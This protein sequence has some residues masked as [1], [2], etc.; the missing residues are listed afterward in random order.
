MNLKQQADNGTLPSLKY[1]KS[2][3]GKYVSLDRLKSKISEL[4]SKQKKLRTRY[5]FAKNAEKEL[6]SIKRNVD[7]MLEEPSLK[8]NRIHQKETPIK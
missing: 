4:I 2:A 1:I 5:Y 8:R 7:N 6:Y 3:P